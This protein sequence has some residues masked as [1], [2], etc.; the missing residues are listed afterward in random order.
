MRDQRPYG[1]R[2]EWQAPEGYGTKVDRPCAG[3]FRMKLCSGGVS[4]GVEIRYGPPLDPVTGEE[5][6]RSWRWIAFTNG[7][8]IDIDRVF[9]QCAGSPIDAEE[10][11]Y[12]SSLQ[13]WGEQHAP[14]S[15][16]ANPHKPIN[17]L[18]APLGI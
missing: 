16:E 12:L 18:T 14:S 6:D 1:E 11:A 4:V 8:P 9:P 17:W 5:L 10:Y 13:T 3:F 2:R 15:P 7:R